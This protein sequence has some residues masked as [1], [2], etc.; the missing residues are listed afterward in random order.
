MGA[1]WPLLDFD[2]IALPLLALKAYPPRRTSVSRALTWGFSLSP[3][4]S[5]T[6]PVG[7]NEIKAER[8]VAWSKPP[9][10]LTEEVD[11]EVFRLG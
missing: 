5:T 9:E 3:S 2:D 7:R 6:P 8:R 4:R 10:R 1:S 11:D